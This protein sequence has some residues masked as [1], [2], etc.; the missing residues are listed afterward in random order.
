MLLCVL[1][2]GGGV[3]RQHFALSGGAED[4]TIEIAFRLAP[5]FVTM[6]RHVQIKKVLE[7]HKEKAAHEAAAAA[8]AAASE[9]AEAAAVA[10]DGSGGDDAHAS[11]SAAASVPSVRA[12]RQLSTVGA[13]SMLGMIYTEDEDYFPFPHLW[14][15][16]WKIVEQAYESEEDEDA[17]LDHRLSHTLRTT[18]L[19]QLSALTQWAPHTM[20]RQ[21]SVP[22][23]ADEL[24]QQQDEHDN[25]AD[26]SRTP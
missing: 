23:E 5:V 24:M 19:P 21:L 4:S 16:E 6:A 11:D 12:T 1:C 18:S 15:A 3:I 9:T 17:E 2:A 13:P 20:Q 10:A 26:G 22:L 25:V 7:E 14:P 8:V